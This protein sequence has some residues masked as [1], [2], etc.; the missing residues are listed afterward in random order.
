M[1]AFTDY[2]FNFSKNMV[3]SFWVKDALLGGMRPGGASLLTL[4]CHSC[5]GGGRHFHSSP[6]HSQGLKNT[7]FFLLEHTL[8]ASLDFGRQGTGVHS[9][10]PF[11]FSNFTCQIFLFFS[12]LPSNCSLHLNLK[13]IKTATAF[14]IW[15]A[16]FCA[17]FI[18]FSFL[19]F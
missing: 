13:I 1:K 9:H 4:V 12:F 11:S 19:W 6:K 10:G 2:I 17:S 15:Q 3:F 18:T 8:T 5:R 16:R 7:N 14:N